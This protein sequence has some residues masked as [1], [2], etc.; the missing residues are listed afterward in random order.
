MKILYVTDIHGAEW[1]YEKALKRAKKFGA[2]AVLN[3]GD[4]YPKNIDPLQQ[5]RFV[6]DFLSEHFRKY[7]EAGIHLTLFP[8]NDDLA[9]FDDALARAAQGL[10]FVHL[11]ERGLV[12]IGRHEVV[13]FGLVPDYPFRLKDRCRRDDEGFVHPQQFGSGLVS[14]MTGDDGGARPELVELDDWVEHA[15]GLPTIE[16]ELARLPSPE[17]TE[18]AIYVIHCPPAGMRLDMCASGATPGSNAV[19]RFVREKQ[20]LLTLH[21]HIHES[22]RVG[23]AWRVEAGRT[24]CVQPGQMARLAYVLI[25]TD[26]NTQKRVEE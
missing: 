4:L 17:D 16:Q 26:E 10:E 19:A 12:R 1:K 2:E 22:P 21:G 5:D 7:E 8:G 3:G 11:N 20:P 24:A 15:R 14:R 6:W 18:N 13:G 23:G 25:D 9:A